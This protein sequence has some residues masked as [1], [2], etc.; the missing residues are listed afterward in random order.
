MKIQKETIAITTLLATGALSLPVL[1]SGFLAGQLLGMRVASLFISASAAIITA[2]A[3]ISAYTGSAFAQNTVVLAKKHFGHIGVIMVSVALAIALT[4]WFAIQTIFICDAA[5]S[6]FPMIPSTLCILSIGALLTLT[7]MLDLAHLGRIAASLAIPLA[8]IIGLILMYLPSHPTTINATLSNSILAF[9]GLLGT[10]ITATLELPILYE[11]T[12]LPKQAL[13]SSI[14]IFGLFIP[15]IQIIG[16]TIGAR[17]GSGADIIETLVTSIP[18]GCKVVA[19]LIVCSGIIANLLNLFSSSESLKSIFPSLGSKRSIIVAGGAGTFLALLPI[20]HNL[21]SF[22]SLLTVSAGSLSL[23]MVHTYLMKLRNQSR[24]I[25]RPK[26]ALVIWL[27]A[28]AA[29]IISQI[30]ETTHPLLNPLITTFVITSALI[31]LQIKTP[32]KQRISS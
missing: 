9:G 12:K 23:I 3:V 1:T 22:F 19:I 21:L 7:R 4:G 13:L 20:T 31:A 2:L 6:L 8:V 29:G 27:S 18:G 30:L 17:S 24:R 26:Q 15:L 11:S 14:G 16:A 5:K 25:L 28:S 32:V 10:T